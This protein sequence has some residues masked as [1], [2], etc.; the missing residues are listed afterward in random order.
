MDK[1]FLFLLNSFINMK[2]TRWLRKR[3]ILMKKWRQPVR[4]KITPRKYHI[5]AKPYARLFFPLRKQR[6]KK[7]ARWKDG[8]RNPRL[9]WRQDRYSKSLH[10]GTTYVVTDSEEVNLN[11]DSTRLRDDIWIKLCKT[12]KTSIQEYHNY[13]VK[14]TKNVSSLRWLHA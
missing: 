3:K 5:C 7:L 9:W 14:D 4:R 6:P 8:S 12:G 1:W 13:L 2:D 10:C 11:K